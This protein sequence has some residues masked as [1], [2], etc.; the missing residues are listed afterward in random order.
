MVKQQ[1]QRGERLSHPAADYK[2]LL[3]IVFIVRCGVSMQFAGLRPL[4]FL[5]IFIVRR[6]VVLNVPNVSLRIYDNLE[7]QSHK[8]WDIPHS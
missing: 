3:T 2:L 6:A 1:Q 4:I 5:F 7:R 8:L